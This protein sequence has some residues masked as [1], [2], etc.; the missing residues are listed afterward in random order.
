MIWQN[1]CQERN[2]LREE[3]FW[4]LDFYNLKVLLWS[5]DSFLVA[6][7]MDIVD[8]FWSVH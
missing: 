5:V 7:Y 1:D 8:W 6:N 3:G 2:V 4:F